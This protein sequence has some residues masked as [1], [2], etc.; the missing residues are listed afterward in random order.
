[1]EFK[2]SPVNDAADMQALS[3]IVTQC[4]LD[5][6]EGQQFYVDRIGTDHFR[7]VRQGS[8]VVGGLAL[9]PMGHWFGGHSVSTTGIASVGIAP[10]S[11]GSGA[12]IALMHQTLKEL[13]VNGFALS[14]LYPATQQLY[15][16]ANYEQAGMYCSWQVKTDAIQ[17]RQVL[18]P[19][20]RVEPTDFSCFRPLYQQYAQR[21]MG[22]LDRGEVIWRGAI[23][24]D[25]N[26]V[27][28]A[29]LVGDRDHPQGYVI[30][31]QD[32]TAG[33][34]VIRIRDWVALTAAA[35]K[36]L[37]GF[38]TSHRSMINT[39]H[40]KG[41]LVDPLTLLLPERTVHLTDTQCWL[42]R[43]VNVVSALEQRGYPSSI[44]AELHLEVQ[45]EWLPENHDRFILSV[46]NGRG[47]VQRGGKGDLAISV[48]SLSPLYSGL[49]S[50]RQLQ[51]LGYLSATEETLAIATALFAGTTPWMADF[52]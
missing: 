15:R 49:Y 28:Y 12:A 13:Y 36:T 29:Y 17:L 30:F 39:I 37:W 27:F 34:N 1:M 16:K 23:P 6:P 31:K 40:W 10:E 25:S 24:P 5:T 47:S 44:Q 22:M 11:R 4:F 18:L 26:E 51:Q 52:F 21:Q 14:T 38:F 48:Q 41:A 35:A 3:A 33:G 46:A 43:I 50:P 45:D 9:V 7:V 8:T 42:M 19:I 32:K 2:V 20:T